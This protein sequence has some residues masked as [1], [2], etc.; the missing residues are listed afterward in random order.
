LILIRHGESEWNGVFNK[1]SGVMRFVMMPFRFVLALYKELVISFS[2][3]SVFLDSPLNDDGVDQVCMLMYAT[4]VVSKCT[5]LDTLP[6]VQSH[7]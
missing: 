7:L 2:G 1:G 3:G 4:I 6:P 5:I